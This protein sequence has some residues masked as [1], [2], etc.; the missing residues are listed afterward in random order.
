[1]GLPWSALGLI[2]LQA[3]AEQCSVGVRSIGRFEVSR[4]ASRF[5]SINGM[6]EPKG[7]QVSFPCTCA[8]QE[9]LPTYSPA[10][11]SCPKAAQVDAAVDMRAGWGFGYSSAILLKHHAVP[12]GHSVQGLPVF[13][14]TCMHAERGF[15]GVWRPMLVLCAGNSTLLTKRT[16]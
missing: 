1:M 9:L 5:I 11:H 14:H 6:V 2:G 12:C 15:M 4:A 3:Q 8:A 16:A 7:S 10:A 13:A